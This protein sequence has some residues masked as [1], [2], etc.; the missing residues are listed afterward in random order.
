MSLFSLLGVK[1]EPHPK[2]GK[3]RC[4]KDSI[5]FVFR[6]FFPP[7]VARFIAEACENRMDG[8]WCDKHKF[9]KVVFGERVS[10]GFDGI[11]SVWA[12]PR[13]SVRSLFLV[14]ANVEDFVLVSIYTFAD[15]ISRSTR[16]DVF[17]VLLSSGYRIILLR[18]AKARRIFQHGVCRVCSSG[19]STPT[20][21]YLL[22]CVFWFRMLLFVSWCCV[23]CAGH[24]NR[25][26]IINVHAHLLF[27]LQSC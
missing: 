2:N 24:A 27:K 5:L 7:R 4:P 12:W 15:V 8:R 6:V 1:I 26:L 23:L 16:G 22:G 3:A 25:A 14:V 13:I 11:V 18:G 10:F 19:D 9:S 17:P 20:T 21:L